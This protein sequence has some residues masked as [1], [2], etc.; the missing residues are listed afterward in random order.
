MV[1]DKEDIYDEQISPL[2]AQIISICK[3][4]KIPMCATFQY[5]DDE[6]D[7]GPGYCTTTLPFEGIASDRM[8]Q[9][10]QVMQPQRPICI[11]ETHVTNP[12]GSKTIHI[13]RV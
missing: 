9:I 8:K 11:A 3:E 4:H 13:A 7:N 1:Y 6:G 5:S 12:D 2:M 10:A